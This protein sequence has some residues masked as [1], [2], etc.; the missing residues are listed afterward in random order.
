MEDTRCLVTLGMPSKFI[1]WVS[2][3]DGSNT[4]WIFDV[5]RDHL[6]S[7]LNF[8]IPDLIPEIPVNQIRKCTSH[9]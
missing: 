9:D 6:E 4:I 5:I 7:W 1:L 8:K 2:K 3:P